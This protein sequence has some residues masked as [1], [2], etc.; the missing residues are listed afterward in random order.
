M[1]WQSTNRASMDFDLSSGRTVRYHDPNGPFILS[2]D[3]FKAT[4]ED[5]TGTFWK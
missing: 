4:L 1:S 2:S 5:K 3:E